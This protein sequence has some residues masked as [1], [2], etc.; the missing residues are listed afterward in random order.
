MTLSH[1]SQRG[2]TAS[3]PLLLYLHGAGEVGGDTVQQLRKSGPGRTPCMTQGMLTDPTRLLRFATSMFLP[4]ICRRE[5]ATVR[6]WM[7]SL[8]PISR[9]TRPSNEGDC[10]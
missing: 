7:P 6:R 3:A 5:I 10:S 9:H 4:S 8:R 2:Q 1:I